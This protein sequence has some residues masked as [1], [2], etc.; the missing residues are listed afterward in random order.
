MISLRSDV[1]AFESTAQ[2]EFIEFM[3]LKLDGVAL[4]CLELS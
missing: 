1:L 3:E 2:A 4:H